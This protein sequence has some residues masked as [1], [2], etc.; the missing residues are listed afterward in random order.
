M[1]RIFFLIWIGS[2][3]LFT[4][5][6]REQD[7]LLSICKGATVD[8]FDPNFKV[9]CPSQQ[10]DYFLPVHYGC[11]PIGKGISPPIAWSGIPAGSTNLRV[12]IE[13][14]TCAYMCNSCCKYHHW[15]LDV[16]VS[17]MSEGGV[18]TQKG[19]AEGASSN[20]AIQKYVYP[21]SSDK[22]AFMPFCPP[23]IQTHAYIYRLIAYKNDDGKITITGRSQSMP[24]LFSLKGSP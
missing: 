4:S 16:P 19:I 6:E 1:K 12:I 8:S 5:C 22:K 2:L 20:P 7:P 15:V 11:P 10:S 13:D 21:N 17:E 3:S 9:W 18:I 24:L 14:A 23:K